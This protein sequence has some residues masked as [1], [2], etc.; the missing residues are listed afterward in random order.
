MRLG[1]L[2]G[3]SQAVLTL[4]PEALPWGMLEPN[5]TQLL[6]YSSANDI[7]SAHSSTGECQMEQPATASSQG[8]KSLRCTLEVFNDQCK[9]GSG[10]GSSQGD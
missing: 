8:E 9:L 5:L 3:S 6:F 10:V 1:I 4:G 7:T 2:R